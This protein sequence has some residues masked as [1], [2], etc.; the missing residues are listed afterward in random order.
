MA[1]DVY[2]LV[3]IFS[4]TQDRQVAHS[5]EKIEVERPP[6]VNCDVWVAI[7]ALRVI[8]R[9]VL[10]L[11]FLIFPLLLLTP[12]HAILLIQILRLAYLFQIFDDVVSLPLEVFIWE[13][14]ELDFTWLLFFCLESLAGQLVLPGHPPD[15]LCSRPS[16]LTA[17]VAEEFLIFGESHFPEAV[18]AGEVEVSIAI[19]FCAWNGGSKLPTQ[20]TLLVYQFRLLVVKVNDQAFIVIKYVI[21]PE[22]AV[23]V[24][25]H[26][27]FVR[28]KTPGHCELTFLFA[29]HTDQMLLWVNN[30]WIFP[31][32]HFWVRRFATVAAVRFRVTT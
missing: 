5:I 25:I 4:E 31:T 12:V 17:W 15:V 8:L 27:Q 16:S 23:H 6:L 26:V 14:L 2:N 11:S 32:A 30:L 10:L 7:F 20:R 29:E 9:N 19:L 24:D 3:D 18:G 28:N 22:S 21:R 13:V 1:H